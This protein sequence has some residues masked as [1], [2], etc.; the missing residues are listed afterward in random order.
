VAESWLSVLTES[1]LEDGDWALWTLGGLLTAAL[2]CFTA[3]VVS[4]TY[5]RLARG[6]AE[7]G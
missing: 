6:A 1:P 4:M 7:A 5:A 2:L 3:P